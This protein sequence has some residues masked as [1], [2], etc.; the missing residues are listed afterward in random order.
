[1]AEYG[2][3]QVGWE[4]VGTGGSLFYGGTLVLSRNIP[5]FRLVDG[6]R[7]GVSHPGYYL[8]EDGHLAK[9]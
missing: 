5:S 7:H 9:R 8:N 3:L 1:M 2:D 6:G 4:A